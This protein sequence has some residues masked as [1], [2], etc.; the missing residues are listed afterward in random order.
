M[1]GMSKLLPPFHK[2]MDSELHCHLANDRI[3]ELE[4]KLKRANRRKANTE[5]NAMVRRSDENLYRAERAEAEAAAVGSD[6]QDHVEYATRL[7]E[8]AEQ[9]EDEAE[10]TRKEA[11]EYW[12]DLGNVRADFDEIATRCSDSEAALF[13]SRETIKQWQICGQHCPA[14][15][16]FET[17][18]QKPKVEYLGCLRKQSDSNRLMNKTAAPIG[19]R[20]PYI[21]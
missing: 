6:L 3:A 1:E 12:R 8:R 11:E 21:Y 9:A 17:V 5:W 13:H 19:R 4:A 16:L 14:C 15:V 2:P 7:R 18:F 20:C 10:K